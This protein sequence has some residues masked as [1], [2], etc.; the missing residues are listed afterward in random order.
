MRLAVVIPWCHDKPRRDEA[1]LPSSP[2]PRCRVA[3]HA[4]GRLAADRRH[5]HRGD[6]HRIRRPR[7]CRLPG[8]ARPPRRRVDADRTRWRRC[9]AARSRSSSLACRRW[10]PRI[11]RTA[12]CASRAISAIALDAVEL[13]FIAVGTPADESGATDLDAVTAA[14][15]RSARAG[16]PA[17]VVVQVDGA[18]RHTERLQQRSA[19]R[20]RRAAARWRVPVVGNPEFLREGS[21]TDDFMHPDRIVIGAMATTAARVAARAMRRSSNAACRC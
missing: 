18:G 16:A 12:G 20:S 21:A 9:S 6:R 4:S 19:A 7:R 14:P 8:R 10:S 5:G 1:G 13:I 2:R 3:R 11:G 15:R 17:T